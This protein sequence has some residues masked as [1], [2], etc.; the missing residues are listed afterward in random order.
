MLEYFPTTFHFGETF[1][2]NFFFLFCL[3][4]LLC[5]INHKSSH[6]NPTRAP[7]RWGFGLR[8]YYVRILLLDLRRTLA[9]TLPMKISTC[10][11]NFQSYSKA[12]RKARNSLSFFLASKYILTNFNYIEYNFSYYFF[13]CIDLEHFHIW[14]DC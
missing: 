2:F 13:P 12:L 5:F 11:A 14:S 4:Y 7:N 6:F 3:F 1:L 8:I 9:C 10:V